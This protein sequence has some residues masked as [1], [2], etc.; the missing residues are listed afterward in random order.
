MI[1][2]LI[3]SPI[4]YISRY[5]SQSSFDQC[6]FETENFFSEYLPYRP[7]R[8]P[9]RVDMFKFTSNRH[10]A[11]RHRSMQS[12]RLHGVAAAL[13]SRE[14]SRRHQSRR[15]PLLVSENAFEIRLL[16]AGKGE[17]SPGLRSTAARFDIHASNKWCEL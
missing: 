9:R 7:R 11:L 4:Q 10:D 1:L 8:V 13:L 6:H 3:P 5:A 16:Y 2:R 15:S 12:R 17:T 14:L